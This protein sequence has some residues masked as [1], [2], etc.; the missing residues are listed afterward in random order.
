MH[1]KEPSQA[2][3]DDIVDFVKKFIINQ[4]AT[5]REYGDCPKKKKRVL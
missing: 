4:E 1:F 2:E 3:K 5:S